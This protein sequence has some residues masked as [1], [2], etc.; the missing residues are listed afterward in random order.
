MENPDTIEL[1]TLSNKSQR[2]RIVIPE[3]NKVINK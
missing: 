2:K 3:K 1:Q